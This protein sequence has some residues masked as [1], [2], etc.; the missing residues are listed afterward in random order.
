[1]S[2]VHECTSCDNLS[3][4]P[5]QVGKRKR[6]EVPAN[7]LARDKNAEPEE[8]EPPCKNA[9]FEAVE[10]MDITMTNS[11]PLSSTSSSVKEVVEESEVVRREIE[12]SSSN[13]EEGVDSHSTEKRGVGECVEAS[14][15]STQTSTVEASGVVSLSIKKEKR[16]EGGVNGRAQVE[17]NK[18]TDSQS[19]LKRKSLEEEKAMVSDYY[20]HGIM[21]M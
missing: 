20:V 16:E 12:R 2:N 13:A 14:E 3:C 21:V 11:E 1:M 4:D 17:N 8:V 7:T 18:G 6:E 5:F 15:P 9:R 19:L 10:G